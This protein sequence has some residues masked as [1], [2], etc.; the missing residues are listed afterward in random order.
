MKCFGINV[1]DLARF[2]LGERGVIAIQVVVFSV[3]LLT[4]SGFVIDFGRAYTSQ[5]KL[6]SFVDKAAL[7]AAEALD[8]SQGAIANAIAAANAA[9]GP[10][11]QFEGW[12][13]A[14]PEIE[15]IT[16]LSAAPTNAQGEFDAQLVSTLG[17]ETTDAKA[18]EYVIVRA[19]PATVRMTLTRMTLGAL[20]PNDLNEISF[21]A[22]SVAMRTNVICGPVSTLV[23]CNPFEGGPNS[24]AETMEGH[25]GTQFMLTADL[26]PST[27]APRLKA[28]DNHIRVGL[29]KNPID[30][31]GADP[32]AVCHGA[33]LSVFAQDGWIS[34]STDE[35]RLDGRFYR[36]GPPQGT[37]DLF[38]SDPTKDAKGKIDYASDGDGPTLELR[39]GAAIEGQGVRFDGQND[40][41]FIEDD[42]HS[43][44]DTGR[45]SIT[46][47]LD[48]TDGPQTLVSKDANNFR[49]GGHV[50]M[51][52][53]N[54]A[55]LVRLQTTQQNH[56]VRT[57]HILKK[58]TIYTV[59]FDFG[60]G[61]MAVYI[62]DELH[63]GQ[64]T[65]DFYGGIAG[66]EEAWAFGANQWNSR[67]G[68]VGS[69]QQYFDGV[70]YDFSV[71]NRDTASESQGVGFNFGFGPPEPLDDGWTYPTTSE[72]MERLRDTCLLAMVD[73][74]M[75]CIGNQVVVKAAYPGDIVT[76]LNT[77]FDLWDAP[78]D[79]R[80]HN[81]DPSTDAIQPDYVAVHG[82][83]TRAEFH[84]YLY[85]ALGENYEEYSAELQE[86]IDQ[87]TEEADRAITEASR[88]LYLEWAAQMQADYDM[89]LQM[90][91]D[92]LEVVNAYPATVTNP[93]S[94]NNH[95][96]MGTGLGFGP[97]YRG[98][99]F[100]D[101]ENCTFHP[102]VDVLSDGVDVSDETLVL[103]A[104]PQTGWTNG[105]KQNLT[106]LGAS[107]SGLSSA[108]RFTNPFPE[109][110]EAHLKFY[111]S[112][113]DG[114][115]FMVPAESRLNVQVPGKGTAIAN[116]DTGRKV[117]KATCPFSACGYS[118][119]SGEVTSPDAGG[120]DNPLSFQEYFKNYY[121]PFV[122]FNEMDI[123]N[124]TTELEV[125]VADATSMYE[126]YSTVERT[127]PN[128]WPE[129]S[130]NGVGNA[131]AYISTAPTNYNFG[132]SDP[133]QV[134]LT[135]RR[136]QR[137]TLVN[138]GA[139]ASHELHTGSY[140][141]FY[142]DSYVADVVDIVDVFLIEAPE[143]ANCVPGSHGDDPL[144]LNP[145]FN[146]GI[147]SAHLYV[148]FISSV[149]QT[150]PSELSERSYAT[151]VH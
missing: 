66:N 8:G 50:T 38:P 58:D 57:S 140:E 120:S 137:V 121:T 82:M 111:G 32:Y 4:A 115:T 83:L 105:T 106:S 148:E 124:P 1:S 3:V 85:L 15:S 135:E 9:N 25:V 34:D 118:G 144:G 44:I 59:D 63:G 93:A 74:G 46:F 98:A 146:D 147:E 101:P 108:W 141:A 28:D 123:D 13:E 18:A 72:E 54:G 29:L 89:Q 125:L 14:E 10:S 76:G 109:A 53:D 112:S 16:F 51:R 21:G 92:I 60:E 5:S 136:R 119:L 132:A 142:A 138:C 40:Y 65:K 107:E 33:G 23:M 19:A 30:E 24:F 64:S 150:I 75:Q 103:I 62:D 20:D 128:L 139:M 55:I 97:M 6:Q 149:Q 42:G 145:C 99:C 67:E 41:A 113:G 80:L 12:L 17:L 91:A 48:R 26:D 56:E 133:Q 114:W 87:Y 96:L 27:G 73:S 7:A 70:I 143:V 49:N 134:Q 126:G 37:P 22:V 79:R 127:T 130:T 81:T 52:V 39:N 88:T 104:A 129:S 61:G 95:V 69:L 100:E 90:E 131:N 84:E 2:A 122:N 31:I 94:R 116:Y 78:L 45:I 71:T 110:S 86:L 43:Q 77:I 68:E 151:L 36:L 35:A 11:G 47:S 117:T 102:Y